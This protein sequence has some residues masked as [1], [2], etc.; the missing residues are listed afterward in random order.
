MPILPPQGRFDIAVEDK[1]LEEVDCDSTVELLADYIARQLKAQSPEDDFKVIAYE[2]VA[3][4]TLLQVFKFNLASAANVVLLT[5]C[6]STQAAD[7]LAINLSGEVKQGW[8]N[9]R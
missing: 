4:E 9:G 6:L 8:F 7:K 3:K 2:G 5:L 1:I